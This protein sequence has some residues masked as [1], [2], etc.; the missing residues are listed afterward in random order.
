MAVRIDE[1][2]DKSPPKRLGVEYEL[3]WADFDQGRSLSV[4]QKPEK[5]PSDQYPALGRKTEGAIAQVR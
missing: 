4:L 3:Q 1:A 2:S 5:G